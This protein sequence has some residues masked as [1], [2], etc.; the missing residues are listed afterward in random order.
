[1]GV[2]KI[3]SQKNTF[4]DRR[5][6]SC[7]WHFWWRRFKDHI[8][9]LNRLCLILYADN[10]LLIAR[11]LTIL[12][13]LLHKCELKLLWIDMAI[14]Y[15]KSCCLR[16]GPRAEVVCNGL[17]CLSGAPIAWANGVRYLRI[18]IV[19]SWTFQCSLDHAKRS[20]YRTVN[21]IFGKVG[22]VAF[23]KVT[24]Y[25]MKSKCIPL[26]LYAHCMPTEYISDRITW[27]CH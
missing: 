23:E 3:W 1:M 9:G 4:N 25:L 22:R 13:K 26:L 18:F 16:I 2:G 10:I 11:C 17:M 21:A 19:K 8:I 12:D 20:F 6:I 27:F 15:N 5:Q 14:N 7:L 24:L